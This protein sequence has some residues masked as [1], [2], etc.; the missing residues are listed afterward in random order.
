MNPKNLLFLLFFGAALS[1][2]T[3]TWC[4]WINKPSKKTPQE[5]IEGIQLKLD[6]CLDKQKSCLA[7][8]TTCQNLLDTCNKTNN[9]LSQQLQTQKQVS[10][11]LKDQLNTAENKP[12]LEK[13][14][15]IDE[16][17]KLLSDPAK[18][19][20]KINSWLVLNATLPITRIIMDGN[21][22]ETDKTLLA[23]KIV[24]ITRALDPQHTG[25]SSYLTKQTLY[26][27]I[28]GVAAGY[29][30]GCHHGS[31]KKK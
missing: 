18:N 17:K 10:A 14:A 30:M 23:N 11:D 7:D 5:T 16:L 3:S 4:D 24:T 2:T 13:E 31:S 20:K 9:D 25:L 1:H 19:E 6:D 15:K 26:V 29:L 21:F 8:V 28:G 12:A 27:L 22:S